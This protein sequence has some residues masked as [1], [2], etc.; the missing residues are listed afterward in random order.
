[1]KMNRWIS[2][3]LALLLLSAT[4]PAFAE[5]G[6]SGSMSIVADGYYFSTLAV[7]N[8]QLYALGSLEEAPAPRLY[9]IDLK[10]GQADNQPFELGQDLSEE[11]I[12][13]LSGLYADD[14]GLLAF[15][16]N[17]YAFFRIK[18]AENT[19]TIRQLAATTDYLDMFADKYPEV[20]TYQAPYFYIKAQ[21]QLY[22]LHLDTG[23]VASM[24]AGDIRTLSPY[25]EGKLLAMEM[26]RG[27]EGWMHAFV[28]YDVEN[29]TKESM[30]QPIS[31]IS[32]YT[33]VYD[34]SMDRVITADAS[35]MYAISLKDSSVT[36]IAPIAKGDTY[37]LTL[38][39]ADKAAIITDGNFL[40][41]RPLSGEAARQDSVTL[42]APLA[43]SSEFM[44]F[45]KSQPDTN[46]V[47]AQ[48]PFDLDVEKRF[49]NDM[50]TRSG[51]I[52]V[53]LLSDQN[54][55]GQIKNKGFAVD[56]SGSSIIAKATAGMEQPFQDAFT[57]DGAILALPQT[58]FVNL[59]V[60]S[61]S[62]L[63]QLDLPVPRTYLEYF[64]LCY[65]ILTE[66]M[67]EFPQ[68]YFDPF[69]NGFD[70]ASVL[71]RIAAELQKN[72]QPLDF[73]TQEIQELL[74]Q[75][76]LVARLPEGSYAQEQEW[77]FY[78]YYLPH[79]PKDRAHLVLTLSPEN[80]PAFTVGADDLKYLVIN[81]FSNNQEAALKLLESTL[82]NQYDGY[83]LVMYQDMAEAIENKDYQQQLQRK[84]E[85]VAMFQQQ[86]DKATGAEKSNLEQQLIYQREDLEAFRESGRYQISPQEV[87]R[88][89]QLAPLAYL[90]DFN[91]IWM[92]ARAYPDFFEEYR[93]NPNFEPKQFLAQ[94]N[95]MV[96]TAL[97]E[98][99]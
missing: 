81:P 79:L 82:I 99:E 83:R 68:F 19:A 18:P 71:A 80:T 74:A 33:A 2:L 42:L 60:V 45:Y 54:L 28:V 49:T 72:G 40:S 98:Q 61:E 76:A 62:G 32:G 36:N 31:G 47:F 50:L 63:A 8:N 55:L 10:S 29:N 26:D 96:K 6:Q 27:P 93:S 56:L 9:R 38:L 86:A 43:R 13:Q 90:P 59:P 30:G 20:T 16:S 44:D 87:D 46:L 41:I 89:R 91:P 69:D 58:L 4:A 95:A 3:A 85:L 92:L 75:I 67:D 37:G 35:W 11:A 84:E 66:K 22:R 52:D 51:E 23:E 1:M 24:E 12:S 94:L 17:L 65:T 70:L 78:S 5:A 77:L 7:Y 48:A 39:P 88:T 21:G 97:L 57:K 15:D 34:A 53:Y 73:E 14:Q 64:Q 25:K